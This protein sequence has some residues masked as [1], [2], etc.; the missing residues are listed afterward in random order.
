MDHQAL[1]HVTYKLQS[2]PSAA[3][4]EERERKNKYCSFLNSISCMKETLDYKISA[5]EES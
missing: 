1:I 4:V 2:M 5:G 3:I